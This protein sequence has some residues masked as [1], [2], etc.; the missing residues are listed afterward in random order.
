MMALRL[1]WAGYR[2]PS[3]VFQDDCVQNYC[4]HLEKATEALH[5][6]GAQLAGMP[7]GRLHRRRILKFSSTIY[8]IVVICAV[9]WGEWLNFHYWRAYWSVSQPK[10]SE[11]LGVLIVA[12]P[13]LVGFR[14]ESHML[15]PLTRW[16]SDRGFSHAIAATQ[17]DL[18]VFLGDLFDEGLEASDTEIKWTIS[19]FSDVF[20]SSIPKVFISGDN[21]V[22]GEAEPV[23]SH[24]T[25]RFSHL[26][27]N[28]FPDSHKLFDRLSLTEI[29]TLEPDL[30][31][32]A[33]DHKAYI[34]HLPRSNGGVINSTE[35]T[36]ILESKLF[37]IG[38][39]EPILE[40]QT[41]TCSYRMGVYDV[42]YGFA[43]IEYSSENEKFTNG[44]VRC[45]L[46]LR[47]DRV[48]RRERKIHCVIFS[49]LVG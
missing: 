37:T 19:R 23:Q 17:P 45:R 48:L 5:P 44:S 36:A 2:T 34:H 46:R 12:D 42:G 43:R 10:S 49:S 32:S 24:L 9:I 21:D 30:I 14:H 26:F 35:F 16:D 28:S 40:L 47:K 33:H 39:D 11:S 20:D 8:P 18:I 22:G 38:G 13:Q 6:K 7:L 31:L 41:P 4:C 15:G 29:A 1:P 27:V 3:N 25:T